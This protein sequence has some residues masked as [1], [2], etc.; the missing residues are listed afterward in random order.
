MRLCFVTFG[1]LFALA[2]ALNASTIGVS[3][4]GTCEGGSC[5]GLPL[6][7]ST[8]E[9]LPFDFLF[10]LANGDTFLIDGSFTDNNNCD[11]ST[12]SNSYALQVTY[13]GKT[14][15]GRHNYRAEGRR[16]CD[17]HRVSGLHYLIDRRLQLWNCRTS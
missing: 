3:V 16:I 10:T 2:A 7:F 8:S 14:F 1:C 15:G 4:N 12:A 13:E 17:I 6:P 5:P 11:G 9:T